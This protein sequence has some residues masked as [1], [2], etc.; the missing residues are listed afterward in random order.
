M[1]SGTALYVSVLGS[2]IVSCSRDRRLCVWVC[3][4]CSQDVCYINESSVPFN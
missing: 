2:M 1:G 3:V 4:K